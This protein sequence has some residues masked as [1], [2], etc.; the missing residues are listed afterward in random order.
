[1]DVANSSEFKALIASWTE[2]EG[3]RDTREG[4]KTTYFPREV[5]PVSFFSFLSLSLSLF[6][7]AVLFHPIRSKQ[8][9]N[10]E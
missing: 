2:G 6:K 10:N 9:F 4:A 1:M 3:G 5:A 8:L 7:P